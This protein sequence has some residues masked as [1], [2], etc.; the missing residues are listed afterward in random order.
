MRL[1][2][3]AGIVLAISMVADAQAPNPTKT[4]RT[5]FTP[6]Q[7]LA[8]PTRGYL[9]PQIPLARALKIAEAFIKKDR[10]DVTSCYLIEAKWVVDETKTKNGGWHFLWVHTSESSRNVLIAVSVDGK[11]YRIHLM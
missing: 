7:D 4:S 3:V 11:P 5:S 10:T 9:P 8:L 2:F 1:L 6:H